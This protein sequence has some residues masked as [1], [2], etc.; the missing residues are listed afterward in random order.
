MVRPRSA[1]EEFLAQVT[2]RDQARSPARPG[3]APVVRRKPALLTTP[4][5]PPARES[6]ASQIDRGL[7]AT[8]LLV[9]VFVG[10]ILLPAHAGGSVLAPFLDR[11]IESLWGPRAQPVPGAARVGAEEVT[12]RE[13]HAEETA[14][15]G[16][17]ADWLFRGAR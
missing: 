2:A 14:S 17:A 6:R 11:C 4:F 15:P 8:I 9:A 12:L 5:V 3:L 16:T 10:I 13:T 7:S 1:A